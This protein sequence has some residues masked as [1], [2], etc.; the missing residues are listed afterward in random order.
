V[1]CSKHSKKE[2]NKNS[3]VMPSRRR[4]PRGKYSFRSIKVSHCSGVF[5][6]KLQQRM[7]RIYSTETAL[8]NSSRWGTARREVVERMQKCAVCWFDLT[9]QG[10][11]RDEEEE[12]R[13]S[14]EPLQFPCCGRVVCGASCLAAA[15]EGG[16]ERATSAN[17][18][19]MFTCPLCDTPVLASEW[20]TIVGKKGDLRDTWLRHWQQ[21]VPDVWTRRT[22]EDEVE[23]T[24]EAWRKW[25]DMEWRTSIL[26]K[27]GAWVKVWK[28]YL[29]LGFTG[30]STAFGWKQLGL[31]TLAMWEGDTNRIWR[32]PSIPE[33][34]LRL[35]WEAVSSD[36]RQ[37]MRIVPVVESVLPD[38]RVALSNKD[39]WF[40]GNESGGDNGREEPE[41]PV[42]VGLDASTGAV[43]E[44]QRCMDVFHE[45]HAA[46]Q[47][48]L[49]APVHVLIG[50]CAQPDCGG[51]LESADGRATWGRCVRCGNGTCVQCEEPQ[52]ESHVC[53]ATA[54]TSRFVTECLGPSDGDENPRQNI[55]NIKTCPGCRA[56]V[57]RT[58]GCPDMSCV[59]G[60]RWNWNTGVALHVPSN[61]TGMMGTRTTI[62]QFTPD[63]FAR[64]RA[65]GT[66]SRLMRTW[67]NMSPLEWWNTWGQQISQE[68]SLI[69]LEE[70]HMAHDTVQ[71]FRDLRPHALRDI[72][73]TRRG[74]R[75]HL[76]NG[77]PCTPALRM[78]RAHDMLGLAR[79][80]NVPES[81]RR[82]WWR[83][84]VMTE[85]FTIGEQQYAQRALRTSMEIF[86]KKTRAC[87]A[88]DLMHKVEWSEEKDVVEDMYFQ[89]RVF[90]DKGWTEGMSSTKFKLEFGHR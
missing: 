59:C 22:R 57:F 21:V 3:N 90:K 19:P 41:I 31:P 25:F 81:T 48:A 42:Y 88:S 36:I 46:V 63:M 74:E 71:Y 4:V 79:A 5:Q 1:L 9:E 75:R 16:A 87:T 70:E 11:D 78:R 45:F 54:S 73:I 52:P 58:E 84:L 37:F 89:F 77:R 34:H 10:E 72:A 44:P 62:S 12:E 29:D 2:K 7:H 15:W 14:V 39:V 30:T 83:L 13:A 53:E 38:I 82:V 68:L 6:V 76:S 65:A 26:L 47:R 33:D 24:A 85:L 64:W 28:N 66:A 50:W 17:L 60:T 61:I 32:F 69:H 80:M 56:V 27:L 49:D 43:I 40:N 51:R 67:R 23:V 20:E 18:T 55:N 8:L 86:T 35:V